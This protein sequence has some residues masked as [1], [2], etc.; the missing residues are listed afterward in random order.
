MIVME[1][2]DFVQSA[3]ELGELGDDWMGEARCFVASWHEADD[4]FQPIGGR[5]SEDEF[6]PDMGLMI[7]EGWGCIPDPFWQ[8][9]WKSHPYETVM[10]D[11]EYWPMSVAMYE[12]YLNGVFDADD[13]E[14]MAR[15]VAGF[16]A[17][18]E[19]AWLKDS[20]PPDE[21]AYKALN[22]TGLPMAYW[23]TGTKED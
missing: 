17:C 9:W 7:V 16:L 4:F 22:D 3:G 2:Q 8:A 15:R 10:I 11:G 23:T 18:V 14:A 1:V 19:N 13:D 21:Y 5:F 20:V 6:S 12:L